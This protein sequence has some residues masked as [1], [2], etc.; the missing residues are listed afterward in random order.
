MKNEVTLSNIQLL[1]NHSENENWDVNRDGKLSIL[2]NWNL[3][4]RFIKW[5]SNRNGEV[6]AKIHTAIKETL[7][8]IASAHEKKQLVYVRN[9]DPKADF[10]KATLAY[11]PQFPAYYLAE[12]ISKSSFSKD[13]S[14]KEIAERI[15]IQKDHYPNSKTIKSASANVDL[16]IL[17]WHEEYPSAFDQN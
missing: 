5:I 17:S 3:I 10:F 8:V 7:D 14:I 16:K 9:E 13:S 2:S 6:T 1:W 15:V 12:K 4:G 11:S